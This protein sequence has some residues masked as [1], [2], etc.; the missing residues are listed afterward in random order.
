MSQF[1]FRDDEKEEAGWDNGNKNSIEG[2]I[3]CECYPLIEEKHLQESFLHF[4]G[5]ELQLR[6][7]ILFKRE[8]QQQSNGRFLVGWMNGMSQHF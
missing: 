5:E 7:E 1:S 2:E 6:A 3:A 4:I 8:V